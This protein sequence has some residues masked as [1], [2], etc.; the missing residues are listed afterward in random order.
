[1]TLDQLE[2]VGLLDENFFMYYEDADLCLRARKAD[3]KVCYTPAASA[4]HFVRKKETKASSKLLTEARFSQYYFVKKH[5]GQP[6]T[7]LIVFRYFLQMVFLFTFGGA[8][9]LLR[10]QTLL[11]WLRDSSWHWALLKKILSPSSET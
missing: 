8:K 4:H 2:T 1:M 10:R 5:Y 6:W 7:V 3:W 11:E 9:S